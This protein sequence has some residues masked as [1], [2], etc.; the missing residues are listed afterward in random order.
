MAHAHDF[1]LSRVTPTARRNPGSPTRAYPPPRLEL[2]AAAPPGVDRAE[3]VAGW[4]FAASSSCSRCCTSVLYSSASRCGRPVAASRDGCPRGTIAEASSGAHH[5]CGIPPRYGV[6][7]TCGIPPRKGVSRAR[8]R[9]ALATPTTMPATQ[10]RKTTNERGRHRAAQ[11]GIDPTRM[12]AEVASS[13]L[14]P[15]KSVHRGL[16]PGPTQLSSSALLQ[17]RSGLGQ[18]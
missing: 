12:T 4:P 9:P 18:R 5:A 16:P 11:K 10:Q 8:G 3:S 13:G 7:T 15:T 6:S 1:A 2:Q 14:S 17:S